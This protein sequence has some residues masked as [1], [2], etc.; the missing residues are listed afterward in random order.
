MEYY[1]TRRSRVSSSAWHDAQE[2]SE[3]AQGS[4]PLNIPAAMNEYRGSKSSADIF[5]FGD[6]LSGR[7]S[8]LG[9]LEVPINRRSNFYSDLTSIS[10]Y[11]PGP[12]N[13][14]DSR[15]PGTSQVSLIDEAVESADNRQTEQPRQKATGRKMVKRVKRKFASFGVAS[16]TKGFFIF[17][18][19]ALCQLGYVLALM[20][21][22]ERL[23][24]ANGNM[25]PRRAVMM[26]PC[27]ASL[28]AF[29]GSIFVWGW[30][31]PNARVG[32]DGVLTAIGLTA[33]MYCFALV[34]KS[35]VRQMDGL[36]GSG[37]IGLLFAAGCR[38]LLL[39][40]REDS[41]AKKFLVIVIFCITLY[42]RLR[43]TTALWQWLIAVA[44]CAGFAP[45][46]PSDE[47]HSSVLLISAFVTAPMLALD[48]WMDIW[49]EECYFPI[50]VA[51]GALAARQFVYTFYLSSDPRISVRLAPTLIGACLAFPFVYFGSNLILVGIVFFGVLVHAFGK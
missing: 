22:E 48:D 42:L 7:I 9:D 3:V 20:N 18:L 13:G 1:D 19:F 11:E 46:W 14:V 27:A 31:T 6:R 12:D 34:E 21:M 32:L 5:S 44:Y 28:V 24:A 10:I 15:T 38:M 43:V 16:P 26:I 29:I 8:G 40:F 50:M 2:P 33:E 17:K 30:S 41:H 39:L 37:V 35:D 47:Q 25:S 49:R 4:V 51:T 45:I 36:R 23:D